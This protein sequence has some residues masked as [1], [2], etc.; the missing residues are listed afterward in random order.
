[1]VQLMKLMTKYNSTLLGLLAE[2]NFRSLWLARTI[3][4]LGSIM[5]PIA[6]SFMLLRK[7]SASDIQGLAAMIVAYQ[8]T[9]NCM[10]LAGGVIADR[11]ARSHIMSWC[12]FASGIAQFG[13]A[14]TVS[15]EHIVW[16]AAIVLFALKGV[17]NSVFL[18]ASAG[19]LPTLIGPD[20]LKPA[21]ALIRVS[22]NVVRLG[23]SG[24]AAAISLLLPIRS[25]LWIDGA[26]FV[27]ASFLLR[28]ISSTENNQKDTSSISFFE[29]LREGWTE[30]SR[31]TWLT[32]PVAQI[33]I[34]NAAGSV[35]M[36]LLGP[37]LISHKQSGII[38]W[39]AL[40][41]VQTAGLIIGGALSFKI[42]PK[43]PL[44][45][46]CVMAGFQAIPM[47]VMVTNAPIY[48]I[49]ISM[50]ANAI[51]VEVLSVIWDTAM[52]KYV[53]GEILSRVASI[54]ML[55]SLSGAPIAVAAIGLLAPRF[56]F[57]A[58]TAELAILV[59]VSVPFAL[60]FKSVRTFPRGVQTSDV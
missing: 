25:V 60:C 41:T 50:F 8:V 3:S 28:K 18:P 13:V 33:A 1:M 36:S 7:G 19:V 51:F 6:L 17:F 53:P 48:F 31:R 44:A 9:Q 43:R 49:G 38:T 37:A 14:F 22:M 47:L 42:N 12:E 15:R 34:I 27:I 23:G 57:S 56:G 30:F 11:V 58:I 55:V 26:S 20:M 40:I 54:D 46:A 29:S 39:S 2:K 5:T 32:V 16:P 24:L 4:T 59:L 52:Q 21:N 45:A 35:F 10:L